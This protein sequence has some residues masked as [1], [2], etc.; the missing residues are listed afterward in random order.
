MIVLKKQKVIFIK[1]RKVAGTSFEI[2]LSKYADKCSIITPVSP[3][4]EKVRKKLGYRGPQNYGYHL[5]EL[6]KR[7]AVAGLLSGK[8]KEKFYNHIDAKRLKVLLGEEIWESYRKIS[9]VRNPFEYALSFY[10]WANRYEDKLPNFELWC[11]ENFD[12]ILKN[13]QQYK[14]N[15]TDII[16]FY[17]RYEFLR[18]DI[19]KLEALYPDFY[20]LWSIFSRIKAKSGIRPNHATVDDVFKEAPKIKRLIEELYYDEIARFGF[21][22]P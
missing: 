11:I 8:P 10:F 19:E 9:I 16:D 17:I 12:W 15:G 2:A 5:A 1:P 13:K 20:G 7:E 4:D 22:V 14:I 21:S 3:S 6:S 18:E